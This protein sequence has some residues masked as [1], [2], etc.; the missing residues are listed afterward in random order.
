[1][2]SGALNTARQLGYALGIAALGLICNNAVSDR[3]TGTPGVH[4]AG[5]A[6]RAIT[7]GQAQAVLASA[8]E[9]RRADVAHAV[10]AAFA[11]GLDMTLLAA[12]GAGLIAAVIIVLALRPRSATEV[13]AAVGEAGASA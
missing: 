1:M 5:G 8:P 6:A 3:L 10:H 13:T 11:H 4:S 7:G 2:A 12:G 9:Q